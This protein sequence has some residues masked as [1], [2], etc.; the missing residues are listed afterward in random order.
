MGNYSGTIRCGHCYTEG[1]NRAGCESLT[2][3]YKRE[4]EHCKANVDPTAY[5]YT[6][7]REQLAKRTGIDP[8]TGESKRKRRATYGGRVCSYCKDNGHNRRTCQTMKDDKT[9]FTAMTVAHRAD[10]LAALREHG[11]G[12]GALVAQDEYGN[13]IPA[14]VTEIL[15]E[16]I[17]KKS[18][19]PTAI[20]AR[21]VTDNRIV[22]LSFPNEVSGNEQSYCRTSMMAPAPTVVPPA[23]WADASNMD[24][25]TVD[26]F[27]TGQGRDYYF[28]REHDKN[29]A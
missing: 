27:D 6:R 26:L 10:V 8:V 19:W 23:G 28:W 2:E 18:P 29:N 12:P 16:S 24:V 13:K 22:R 5:R 21:R 4:W 9:K 20:T 7:V 25:G 15:W 1:H 11:C 17:N 14:L 3:Q